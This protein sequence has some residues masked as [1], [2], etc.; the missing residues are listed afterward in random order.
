M[1]RIFAIGMLITLA[2]SLIFAQDAASRANDVLARLRD[3]RSWQDGDAFNTAVRN[4]DLQDEKAVEA[5]TE[6]LKDS[7]PLIRAWSALFLADSKD[8]GK[9]A[10]PVLT[11]L[12]KDKDFRVRRNS[13]QAIAIIDPKSA[14]PAIPVLLESVEKGDS[15]SIISATALGKIGKAAKPALQVLTKE[16][17]MRK[18]PILD[19]DSN[20]QLSIAAS[21][22]QIAQDGQGLKIL[23]DTISNKAVKSSRRVYAAEKIYQIG[24]LSFPARSILI[25]MLSDNESGVRLYTAA[26]LGSIGDID[27]AIP[28]LVSIL[29]DSIFVYERVDAADA[30]GGFGPNA[31]KA[32]E[33]L[34]NAAMDD[35]NRLVR[36]ASIKA[37]GSLGKDA[38][39]VVPQLEKLIEEADEII[40]STAKKA[41]EAIERK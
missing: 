15:S 14:E 31:I 10:I 4:L 24:K 35:E 3:G 28:V 2:T 5:F 34:I 20:I 33:V 25:T 19:I 8:K 41:I 12:L 30:I 37:V 21:I 22:E 1:K 36:I 40:R 17:D 23:V 16:L 18:S 11:L 38:K 13:A 39:D 7:D 9:T 27:S 26:A 32:K 29:S 6:G